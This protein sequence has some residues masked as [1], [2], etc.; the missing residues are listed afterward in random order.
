M[1]IFTSFII[2]ILATFGFAVQSNSPLKTLLPSCVAGGISWIVY[3]FFTNTTS[4]Y[5]MAGFASAFIVGALG[6]FFARRY[7][8]PSTVFILPGLIPLVPGAG[9]YYSMSHLISQEYLLFA[10]KSAETFFIAAS[11]SLGIVVA[12]VFSRSLKRVKYKRV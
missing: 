8:K 12:S 3:D 2:S 10:K 9:M 4:N 1:D 5:I 7:Q 6:E 11:L